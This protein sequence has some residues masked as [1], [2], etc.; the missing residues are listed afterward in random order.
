[1][2]QT[3]AAFMWS[4]TSFKERPL[5]YIGVSAAIFVRYFM[6]LFFFF[7]GV[8]KIR[9]GWMWTD[10]LKGVFEARIADLGKADQSAI[11]AFG[12]M[13]LKVLAL[14]FYVPIAYVVA[15][16]ELYVGIACFAGLTSRWAGAMAFFLMF[17]FAIGG[18]YDASL[19][20]LCLLALVIVFTPSGHWLGMDRRMAAKYPGAIWFR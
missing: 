13:Y 4:R 18:Y 15:L 12:L 6:G 14:P 1:M 20:P 16:G 9:N 7:A 5:R 2:T 17:N 3:P 10:Y 19:I 11:D 8:N